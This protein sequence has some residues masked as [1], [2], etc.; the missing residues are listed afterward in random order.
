MRHTY[1]SGM[2]RRFALAAAIG[3][4][5]AALP[6]VAGA[7]EEGGSGIGQIS[8]LGFNLPALITQLINFALLLVLLRLFVYKPVLRLLDERRR[9]IQEGLGRAAEATSQAQA[10]EQEA[11]RIVEQAQQESRQSIQQAQEGAARLRAELEERA[12]RDAET[13]VTRARQEVQAERDQ[14][15]AQLRREFADLTIAAAERVTRQAIDRQ[16]HQ[17]L[18]DEVLLESRF[19]SDG[20]S[21]N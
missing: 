20:G 14:A 6:A 16:A 15:I 2:A 10:S 7:Q 21:R 19:G 8:K 11:R 12:R 3:I 17:R 5:F 4:A 9:R 13:I 1:G 18:I